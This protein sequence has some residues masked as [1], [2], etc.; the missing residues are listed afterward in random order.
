MTHFASK[1]AAAAALLMAGGAANAYLL[2][3]VGQTNGGATNESFSCRSD[4]FDGCGTAGG[5][6]TNPTT[7]RVTRSFFQ[8]DGSQFN[9]LTGGGLT[10][11]IEFS[12]IVG[13][14][15]INSTNGTSNLP[16][17]PNL[18]QT[19]TSSLSVNRVS[20]SG[21]NS[22][23]LFIGISAFNF[24]QPDSLVKTL[25][26]SATI[27]GAGVGSMTSSFWANPNNESTKLAG[28]GVS[29]SYVL[30]ANGGCTSPAIQWNDP[31]PN[32]G[33]PAYYSM[34]SLHSSHTFRLNNGSSFSGST[35]TQAERVPEP[36]T[37]GLVGVALLAAA[38]VARRK[39]A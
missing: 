1:L 34:F 23:Q 4:T 36:A 2:Y 10:D 8:A 28:L 38:A 9:V 18:A 29:C 37:L 33:D 7:G 13:N 12:G 22:A 11:T 16:G 19:S 26:G 27:S 6:S 39:A 5:V 3:S 20:N 24:S 30:A 25:F 35:S 32:V 14:Y 21:G 15:S 17:A 31:L